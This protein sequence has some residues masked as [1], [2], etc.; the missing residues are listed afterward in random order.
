MTIDQYQGFDRPPLNTSLVR[1]ATA[2][3]GRRS[4]TRAMMSESARWSQ[5]AA[6]SGAATKSGLEVSVAAGFGSL[7]PFDVQTAPVSAFW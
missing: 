3:L 7:G 1:C 4:S 5:L 2:E 6:H